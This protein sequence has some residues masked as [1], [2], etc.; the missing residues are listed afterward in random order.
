MQ[1]FNLPLQKAHQQIGQLYGSCSSLLL[2]EQISKHDGLSIIVTNDMLEAEQIEKELSF[3][4]HSNEIFH[5]PDLETL[6]YDVFS[7]HQD[8]ISERLSTL[9][10][11]TTV[12]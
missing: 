3:F 11:L 12:K 5:L 10:K 7:P 8:I 9:Y 2:N 4:G 1:F 6:P